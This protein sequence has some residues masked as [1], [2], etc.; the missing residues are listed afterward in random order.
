LTSCGSNNDNQDIKQYRS[1]LDSLWGPKPQ[2]TI[3]S[4]RKTSKAESKDSALEATS[5]HASQSKKPIKA[6]PA[7]FPVNTPPAQAKHESL[8]SD[9]SNGAK[10]G[11]LPKKP[12]TSLD[13]ITKAIKATQDTKKLPKTIPANKSKQIT[14]HTTAKTSSVPIEQTI[15]AAPTTREEALQTA[16]YYIKRARAYSAEARFDSVYYYAD[17]AVSIFENGSGFYLKALGQFKLGNYSTALMSIEAAMNYPG[18]YWH[19]SDFKDSYKLNAQI[20]TAI[21][22]KYPSITSKE[23]AHSAWLLYEAQQSR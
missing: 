5:N 3:A 4:T 8:V 2:Q 11:V 22:D 1:S 13:T 10:K 7:Q 12:K 23:K 19:S 9:S 20:C 15:K 6:P 14:S 17:K 21:A 18:G 16:Q